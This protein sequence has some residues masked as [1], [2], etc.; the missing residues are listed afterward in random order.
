MGIYDY[1]HQLFLAHPFIFSLTLFSVFVISYVVDSL[2]T[3]PEEKAYLREIKRKEIS[4]SLR[5]WR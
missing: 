2:T 1:L 5:K 3:T 4:D